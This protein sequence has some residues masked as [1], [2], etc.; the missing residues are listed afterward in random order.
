MRTLTLRLIICFLL[1]TQAVA[2][3]LTYEQL[4]QQVNQGQQQ[5]TA[6]KS[7]SQ[8]ATGKIPEGGDKPDFVRLTDGRIVPYGPGIVCSEECLQSDAL[9]L[10]DEA[11]PRL[12]PNVFRPWLLAIPA[13]VG[14][15]VICAVLCRGGDS[16]T[17][18]SSA[19]P[20]VINPPVPPV[21]DVPEPA[22][23]VL[24]GVGLAMMARHGFGR[25]KSSDR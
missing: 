22:T 8:Q 10:S 14:G 11:V 24:L 7:D 19:T 16:P 3:P 25:K 18:V 17:N 23:L 5:T 12:T 1:A 6:K 9:A 4:A 21:T 20:P 13:I 15:V 2:T